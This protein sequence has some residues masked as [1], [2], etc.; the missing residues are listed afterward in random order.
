MKLITN[1]SIPE[2][3]KTLKFRDAHAKIS[4]I[5]IIISVGIFLI[6]VMMMTVAL[7]R[8][9]DRQAEMTRLI[10]LA[11]A[12]GGDI[13]IAHQIYDAIQKVSKLTKLPDNEVPIFATIADVAKLQ[14][15]TTFKDAVNGDQI[16]F[17]AKS[18][19]IYVYRPQANK[20][21]AQGPFALPTP[22]APPPTQPEPTITIISPTEEI[23]EGSP[24]PSANS[25]PT[26]PEAN[27]MGP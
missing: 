4:R 20:I 3:R 24:S 2:D 18:Q 13:T 23:T 8:S 5:L 17:Y 27:I 25:P 16:L 6:A 19:W 14:A 9:L 26:S 12:Q 22:T 7:R 15:Q 10:G 21:V 11:E 1:T